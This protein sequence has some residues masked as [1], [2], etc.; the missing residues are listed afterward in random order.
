MFHNNTS[1]Q[2]ARNPNIRVSQRSLNL[3]LRTKYKEWAQSRNMRRLT[4]YKYQARGL[5]VRLRAEYKGDP[6]SIGW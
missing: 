1:S 4:K 2:L 3:R 6:Q 5:I